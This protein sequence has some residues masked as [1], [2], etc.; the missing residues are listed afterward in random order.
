MSKSVVAIGVKNALGKKV[1]NYQS[2]NPLPKK[3]DQPSTTGTLSTSRGT[4]SFRTIRAEYVQIFLGGEITY[5]RNRPLNALYHNTTTCRVYDRVRSTHNP[6]S[7]IKERSRSF[8]PARRR[9]HD[10][11]FT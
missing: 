9:L 8:S 2:T 6:Q 3:Q 5:E 1:Q 10:R 11:P 4:N 7:K